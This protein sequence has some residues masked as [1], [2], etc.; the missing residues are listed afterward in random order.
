M[1]PPGAAKVAQTSF[2]FNA[3]YGVEPR[4]LAVLHVL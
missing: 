2:K 3:E 4:S 1:P